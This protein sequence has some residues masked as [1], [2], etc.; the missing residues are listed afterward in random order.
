MR[1]ATTL[2]FLLLMLPATAAYADIILA[3]QGAL[4]PT[5]LSQESYQLQTPQLGDSILARSRAKNPAT[6]GETLQ[7]FINEGALVLGLIGAIAGGIGVITVIVGNA[8]V[9]AKGGTRQALLGWGITSTI[10]GGGLYIG[11]VILLLA[12]GPFNMLATLIPCLLFLGLGI[13]N[14]VRGSRVKVWP[15]VTTK[16]GNTSGGLLFQGSF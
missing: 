1:T 4:K 7:P 2:A 11:T 10:L 12:A 15:Y 5:H 13:P 14:I 3:P 8:V 6:Y 9:L 16:N